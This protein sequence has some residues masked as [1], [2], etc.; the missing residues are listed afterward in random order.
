VAHTH[1]SIHLV[2]TFDSG[3]SSAALRDALDMP[4][5]GDLRNRVLALTVPWGPG[6]EALVHLLGHRLPEKGE[7]EAL[8][9]ELRAL[10]DTAPDAVASLA[11]RCL[12]AVPPDF[13]LHRA[14]VGNLVLAGAY[15]EEGRHL[16]RAVERF[17]GLVPVRGMVQPV[18]EASCHLAA[19]LDDG[20]VVTGQH[21]ITR[22][23][24]ARDGRRIEELYLVTSPSDPSPVTA[25]AEP[26]A[27]EAIA[28]ADLVCYPPGSFRTSLQ[29]AVLPR[30][31]GDAVAASAAPKVYVPNPPG[32]AEEAG[33]A[34]VERVR[35]LAATL[36][37]GRGG[38]RPVARVLDTVLV[39]VAQRP[40]PQTLSELE[41]LGVRFVTAELG[42]RGAE[43][44]YS[45]QALAEALLSLATER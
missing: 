35:I 21:R 4:A 26:R 23:V 34:W 33:T 20:A 27:V 7:R 28:Q 3:G 43:A 17:A 15:L 12:D 13:D 24:W 18:T 16:G 45:D 10:L 38:P 42:G 1:R 8:R 31:M 5:V 14:S 22:G 25:D 11:R 36:G 29:A 19:R 6:E 40:D 30:G 37:A 9:S 44:R 41:D 2:T 32:D 39:D